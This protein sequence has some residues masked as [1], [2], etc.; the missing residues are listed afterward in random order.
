MKKLYTLVFIISLLTISSRAGELA[1][2]P[3]TA[4]VFAV[5]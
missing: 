4:P 1:S 2:S 3:K 5:A